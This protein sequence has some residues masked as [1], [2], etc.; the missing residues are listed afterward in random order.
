M[1]IDCDTHLMPRHA[2][3]GVDGALGLRKPTLKFNDDGLYVDLN[4]RVIL[5]KF[6]EPARCLLLVPA[7]CSR[8]CGMSKHAWK[9]MT[10]NWE[11]SSMLFCR[12]F[13]AGGRISLKP[14]W[15][16]EWRGRITRL[17]LAS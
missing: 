7:R 12:S 11:S 8:A 16:R 10:R 4:F 15:P 9:T 3:D 13:P 17:C 2:F 14:N 5:P 1:I 6:P